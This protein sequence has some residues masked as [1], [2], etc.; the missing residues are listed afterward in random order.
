MPYHSSLK[1]EHANLLEA[2]LSI[3]SRHTDAD[4]MLD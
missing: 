2:S 3:L 1:L 4:V